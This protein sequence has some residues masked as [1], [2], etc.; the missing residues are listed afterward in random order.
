MTAARLAARPGARRALRKPI[1]AAVKGYAYGG[2]AVLAILRYASADQGA[3]RSPGQI[4]WSLAQAFPTSSARDAK[5]DL[6]RPHVDDEALRISL[7]TTSCR[8][9]SWRTPCSTCNQTR[10]SPDAS[11]PREGNH[12][13]S[14]D[15]GRKREL[16]HNI[17][18]RRRRAQRSFRAPPSASCGPTKPLTF[19][20]RPQLFDSLDP[21]APYSQADFDATASSPAPTRS[22]VS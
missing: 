5:R 3:L 22:V 1:I 8:T 14:A 10:A 18:L 13:A 11:Q 17:D 6:H 20:A 19:T 15:R 21:T 9:K 12:I 4:R 7:A 2:G 16:Q